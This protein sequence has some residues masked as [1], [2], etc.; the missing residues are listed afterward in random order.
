MRI[1][2][3]GERYAPSVGG[4]QEVL[5]QLA[6]RFVRRGHDVTVATSKLRD[7]NFSELN[8]VTIKEFEV[9]GNLVR[10]MVGEVE[11]YR[12]FVVEGAHDVIMV[13]A[14]QQWTFD[15]LW[16]VL[17][18]VKAGKVFIPCGF[19]RMY[20]PE[21]T[22]YFQELP[23]VLRQFEHLIFYASDYRDIEFAKRH[24]CTSYTIIPNG[25]SESEFA[26]ESDPSFRARHGIGPN[27]LLFLSVGSLCEE[28]GHLETLKAFMAADLKNL[29]ATLLLNCKEWEQEGR[30]RSARSDRRGW[31]QWKELLRQLYVQMGLLHMGLYILCRVLNKIGLDA[32]L[33]DRNHSDYRGE[34]IKAADQ[35][36]RQGTNK[37]VLI[38]DLD[39]PEVVQAFLNADLY[40]C[41]SH[42]EY[43]PLVLFE[44]A[45]AGTP[46]LSVPVGNAEEIAR[47][48][49]AGVICPAPQDERGYTVP[50]PA[51]LAE[52]MAYL[53]KDR[54][55]LREM[56]AIGR[57]RWGERFTWDHIAQRYERIL[58]AASQE[59][60]KV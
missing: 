30:P 16:P 19:S 33:G 27:E 44:A 49:G 34:M 37:Q 18:E 17:S 40:I 60:C 41:A 29:P 36:R 57:T 20:E 3:C 24:G 26:H 38:T 58:I 52:H 53:V 8:G 12:R 25:A 13:K 5:K 23:G 14:A 56:G 55:R 2:L 28:K 21:F 22:E 47:W 42:I 32:K 50:D 11:A 45:A 46:F 15:A 54:D 39:R 35:I 10:G 6:E 4:V 51:C 31:P 59:L 48:T 9:A 43:S 1:L 7:R